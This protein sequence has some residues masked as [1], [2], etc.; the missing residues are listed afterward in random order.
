V[1]NK[2]HQDKAGNKKEYRFFRL[3]YPLGIDEVK[4]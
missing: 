2:E 4:R 1:A 3:E